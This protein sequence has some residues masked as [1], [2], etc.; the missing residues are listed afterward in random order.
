MRVSIEH[1]HECPLKG[2]REHRPGSLYQVCELDDLVEALD[3]DDPGRPM[4]CP[5]DENDEIT[6]V[7]KEPTPKTSVQVE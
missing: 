2:T 6:F 3:S 4:G 5:L 7:K 1:C